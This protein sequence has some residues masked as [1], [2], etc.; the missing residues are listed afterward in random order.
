MAPIYN[1]IE[2]FGDFMKTYLIVYKHFVGTIGRLSNAVT[3]SQVIEHFGYFDVDVRL[4]G[5]REQLPYCNA[6]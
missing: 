2:R 5:Q 1:I 3:L 6:E 4:V